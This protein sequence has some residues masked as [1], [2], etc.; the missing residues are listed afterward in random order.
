VQRAT[1]L[2]LALLGEV[3]HHHVDVLRADREIHR[4]ADGGNRVLRASVPVGEVATRRDLERAEH[5]VVEVAATHHPERVGVMEI[6]RPGQRGHRLL[7]GVDE[8]GVLLAGGRSRPHA[9]Q[10]VLGVQDDLAILRQVLA[11]SVGRPMPRFTYEP[12]GMSRATRA[13]IWSRV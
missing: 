13:A 4:A 6:R 12:S 9:E 3:L 10:A 8:I 2:A 11:T 1:D 5:A 7:A